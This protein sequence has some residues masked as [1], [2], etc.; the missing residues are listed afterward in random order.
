MPL[1]FFFYG[2]LMAGSGNAVA[3]ELHGRL[4]AGRAG[5]VAGRMYAISDPDGWYPALVA[6][7]GQDD[8]CV[9]GLV[10]EVGA[11]FGAD[12]LAALDAYEAFYPDDPAACEYMRREVTV[13]LAEGG[14]VRAQAYVYVRDLPADAA[15]IAGG[16]FAAFLRERGVAGFAPGK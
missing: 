2:T 14:E 1:R 9:A 12:D 3:D 5:T 15:L 7:A 6:G 16:D 4:G 11:E 13:T 10:H 8:V